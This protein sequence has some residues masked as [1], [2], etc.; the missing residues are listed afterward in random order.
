[1]FWQQA[2]ALDSCS[3]V[4]VCM[5]V[6]I[7][8]QFV[9]HAIL[10][11]VK[12]GTLCTI[13]FF[14]ITLHLA[15]LLLQNPPAR[16]SLRGRGGGAAPLLRRAVPRLAIPLPRPPAPHC[17]PELAPEVGRHHQQQRP[18]QQ[19][20]PA[21]G[22]AVGRQVVPPAE[23]GCRGRPGACSR[24]GVVGVGGWVGGEGLGHAHVPHRRWK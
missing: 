10:P 11:H 18:Q 2:H 20:Q 5:Q 3:H 1:M 12:T 7:T 9:E 21:L 14:K 24:P 17:R 8:E 23:G 16:P 19:E 13:C 4:L 6:H 22:L 15:L